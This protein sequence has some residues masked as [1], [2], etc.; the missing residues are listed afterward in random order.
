[1]K[2]K[3]EI[4]DNAFTYFCIPDTLSREDFGLETIERAV[5]EAL[6]D[7]GW[8]ICSHDTA[9]RSIDT[10]PETIWIHMP[11]A[12]TDSWEYIDA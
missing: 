2:I 8:T 9:I 5:K 10:A 4:I 7:S 12:G 6:Q 1:M 11:T 3:I